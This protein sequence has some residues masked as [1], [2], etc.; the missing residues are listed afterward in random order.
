MPLLHSST[1]W[2]SARA[3]LT[4]TRAVAVGCTHEDKRRAVMTLLKV[5]VND[6][7]TAKVFQSSMQILELL[8][9]D[10]WPAACEA[11]QEVAKK[12]G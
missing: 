8:N 2:E 3:C 6:P 11:A 7:C 12:T 4:S 9:L 1:V 5:A 10:E